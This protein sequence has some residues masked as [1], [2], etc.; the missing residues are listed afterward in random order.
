[1]LTWTPDVLLL[2][3]AMPEMDGC[4]LLTTIRGIERLR[5]VPAVAVTA[6][7]FER[8]KERSANAGFAAH[9]SKP[10]QIEALVDVIGGLVAKKPVDA[11]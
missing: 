6:R 11:V 1:L 7:A 5:E 2:D 10:Y 4:E 3:I 9:V 8:D